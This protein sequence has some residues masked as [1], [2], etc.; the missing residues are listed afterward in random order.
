MSGKQQQSRSGKEG[1]GW[2]AV[3]NVQNLCSK[4]IIIVPQGSGQCTSTG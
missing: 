2:R 4:G 3:E 1:R